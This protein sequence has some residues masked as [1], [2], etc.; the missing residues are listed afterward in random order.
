[1]MNFKTY[2][3]ATK[4]VIPDGV[5]LASNSFSNAFNNMQ[6]LV[7]VSI[8]NAVT[9]ISYTYRNCRNLTDSPKYSNNITNMYYAYANCVNLTGSPVCGPNVISM[10]G[11]YS[12]C[13]NLTG[14]PVCG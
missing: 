2:K 3:N 12:G 7:N 13:S 1:M 9:D 4:I 10:V 5:T 8:P 14:S 6:I 11:A